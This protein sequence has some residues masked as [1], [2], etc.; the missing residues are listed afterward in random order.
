MLAAEKVVA[1]QQSGFLDRAKWKEKVLRKR[2]KHTPGI[3]MAI[4]K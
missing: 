2:E 3:R 4:I 1:G